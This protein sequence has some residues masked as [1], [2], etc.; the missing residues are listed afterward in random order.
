MRLGIGAR[1]TFRLLTAALERQERAS[2]RFGHHARY[3]GVTPNLLF[4]L[5]PVVQRVIR[6]Y[7]K[8]PIKL[9][10]PTRDPTFNFKQGIR[11]ERKGFHTQRHAVYASVTPRLSG[12]LLSVHIL[13][14]RVI[15]IGSE[16]SAPKFRRL[17]TL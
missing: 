9:V 15:H 10:G 13:I 1:F 4:R 11:N 16:G 6:T 7:A 14:H 3:L 8:F 12:I 2:L 5:L 17:A